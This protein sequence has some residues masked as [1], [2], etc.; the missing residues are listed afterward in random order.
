MVPMPP[1]LDTA[2][3]RGPPDVLAMPA[4]MTGYLMPSSLVSGVFS[5]GTEAILIRI[6][7]G[8]GFNVSKLMPGEGERSQR[9]YQVAV[10]FQ[11]TS[12]IYRTESRSLDVGAFIHPQIQA[13]STVRGNQSVGSVAASRN[14]PRPVA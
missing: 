6:S 8:S 9:E 3:A 1:A 11:S 4:S 12:Q 13:M 7:S 14:E 10:K 2:A 5:A